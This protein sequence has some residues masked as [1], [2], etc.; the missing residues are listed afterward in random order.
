MYNDVTIAI[1]FVIV[2]NIVIIVTM[3]IA[4][5]TCGIVVINS[6]TSI[7]RTKTIMN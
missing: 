1:R 5:I 4:L 3:A 6:F 7:L 2:I